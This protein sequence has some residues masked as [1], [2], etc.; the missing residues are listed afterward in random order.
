[1]KAQNLCGLHTQS[2][3]VDEDSDPIFRFSPDATC[4]GV[5]SECSLC[6]LHK[7]R[8]LHGCSAHVLLNL[9]NGSGERDKI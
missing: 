1:M 2:M 5:S 7:T 8:I 4:D 6:T 3:D 9:L